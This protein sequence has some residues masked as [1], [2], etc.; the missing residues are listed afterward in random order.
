MPAVLY[1]LLIWFASSLVA[2]VLLGAGLGIFSYR[3]IQTAFDKFQLMMMQQVN[4]A[5]AEVLSMLSML[6]I[7]YYISVVIGALSAATFIIV[8]KVFVGKG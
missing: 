2:R 3:A 6:G 5:P 7:D 4:Q 8:A 1:G